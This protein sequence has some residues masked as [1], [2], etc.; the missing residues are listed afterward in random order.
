MAEKTFTIPEIKKALAERLRNRIQK[1]ADETAN[2]RKRE[3]SK[4]S[5]LGDAHM[6]PGG[7][8]A[9]Q[10]G[11]AE[12]LEPGRHEKFALNPPATPGP[13]NPDPVGGGAGV[14]PGQLD[15]CPLC[16]RPDVPGECQCLGA[17]AL[18][19]EVAGYPESPPL[20][21]NEACT[22]CGKPGHALDKCGE[23]SKTAV[24]DVTH[25]GAKLPPEKEKEIP[26]E[27]SGGD[28]KPN[29][30]KSE[31]NPLEKGK[32]GRMATAAL[33]AG[34][35]A[36]AAAVKPALD[37]AKDKTAISAKAPAQPEA[38]KLAQK[39]EVKD[40]SGKS[41]TCGKCAAVGTNTQGPPA[42]SPNC[43]NDTKKAEVPQ[44]KPPSGKV[45][46]TSTPPMS[47]TTSKPGLD[48]AADT[49]AGEGVPSAAEAA[50]APKPQFG[51]KDLGA[52]KAKLQA[53]GVQPVSKLG[54]PKPAA[55][56]APGAPNLTPPP[57]A[58]RA[59][60]PKTFSG[61]MG[62]SEDEFGNCAMCSKA[63]HAGACE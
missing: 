55:S 30:L 17:P 18:K 8:E 9:A 5:L 7:H 25:D 52:A 23:M 33:A 53:Q 21:M 44:A 40:A 31:E 13:E 63:E 41:V 46:G 2:L 59:P 43:P 54:L 56:A 28:P 58:M 51:L 36:T 37:H 11:V 19:N 47:S 16:G 27:G 39:A 48:K 12:H 10:V 38:P 4:A 60:A 34:S 26:Q 32:I 42:H 45:P 3:L 14:P 61:L 50:G 57:A 29:A 35:L 1:F 22:K 6:E 15:A 49:W 62:K 24:A 20:A